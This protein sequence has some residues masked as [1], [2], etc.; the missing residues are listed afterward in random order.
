MQYSVTQTSSRY[1][2]LHSKRNCIFLM[3]LPVNKLHFL[4]KNDLRATPP[5][6]NSG[7]GDLDRIIIPAKNGS[8]LVRDF[9]DESLSAAINQILAFNE[10]GISNI[11]ENSRE[12]ALE[13]GIVRYA[14][15]YAELLDQ[16]QSRTRRGS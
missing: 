15:V 14:A 1:A 13:E 10:S 5:P 12:F 8:A 11:R 6:R 4:T 7:V 16:P 2:I 9:S 3:Q